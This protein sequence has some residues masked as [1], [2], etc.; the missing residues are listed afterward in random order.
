MALK[1]NEKFAPRANPPT[2]NYPEGSIKNEST[3]GAKDGT[4]LDAD[5]G[6]DYVGFTDALLAETGI[7]ADGNPDNALASQRV[8]AIKLLHI[9]DL[10]QTYTFKTVALMK[11]SAIIFPVGKKIFWQGYYAE[12]DG[13]SNWGLVKSGAPAEDGGS[14]FTI[15]G[16]LYVE[17]NLKGEKISSLKFG[18]SSSRTATQNTSSIQ[19]AIDYGAALW[20]P[21]GGIGGGGVWIH[22]PAGNYDFEGL[23]DK[24]GV[25]RSGDG[26]N[27]TV[28]NLVGDNKTGMYNQSSISQG[29][30]DQVSYTKLKG[31]AVVPKDPATELPTGQIIWNI[32]G[33]SRLTAED[34]F[35]G[36]C[37]GVIGIQMTGATTAGAGGPANWYNNF[38]DI[39]VE[40]PSAWP[41]GGIGWLL[42]DTAA[43]KE[44]ITTWGIHGGRTSGA[45][46]GT[47]LSV[48]SCNSLNF[49]DHV[50]ESCDVLIG[51]A[52]GP[53]KA[54][55]VN[56]YPAYFEGGVSSDLTIH[57]TADGTGIFGD[58]ITGYTVVDNGVD[59][60]RYGGKVFKTHAKSSGTNFWEVEIENGATR[61]PAFKGSTLPGIDLTNSV[62]TDLTLQNSSSLSSAT[63]FFRLAWSDLT[64][65]LYS[66][67][68]AE[69]TGGADG[70]V[71]VGSAANRFNTVYAT[72]GTINTSDER[73]KTE[74]LDLDESEHA[75]AIELKGAI[76]KFKF[77]DAVESKGESGARIHVG[78]GAQTVKAIFEK[79]GLDPNRYALF[80][81]DEWGDV[82][83]EIDEEVDEDGKVLTEA[84]TLQR[85]EAGNRYGI[86]YEELLAFIIA[87]I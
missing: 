3:P 71:N 21:S 8:D 58:F 38:Y 62:M 81:Y 54:I 78:V 60:H 34:V 20:S 1:I 49:Y 23:E 35:I 40:R 61:R 63:Q 66:F 39:Y 17:A 37:G 87:G 73:A 65:V 4:P 11:S 47:G 72:T 9:N 30:S 16:S 41:T 79:H 28:F 5:W 26:S 15:S 76:K 7:S 55:G 82:F 53:R 42:G 46:S 44:Q 64:T 10:S 19:A 48:Q 52:A 85:Q 36:W 57:P 31:F 59:T 14:I 22:T 29:F 77:K 45:G 70:V 56:F 13:G 6:N 24:Q 68:T 69:F 27:K 33:Y 74:L 83:E 51:S 43:D 67:G 25:N 18:V 75:V 2:T 84:R 86:R 50:I 32:T 12:S 80:C